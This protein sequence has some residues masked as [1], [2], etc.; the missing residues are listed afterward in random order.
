MTFKIFFELIE[1]KAKA[2]SVFPFI[3]GM[4]YSWFHFKQVNVGYMIIFFIAMFLFNMAVDI[5]DNYMDYHNATEDH[6]YKDKT[7]I[8]G[9]ENLSL[10]VIRLMIIG[11]IGIS[12][13]IGIWLAAQTSWVI[14]SLGIISYAI[15]ILYSA[16][17]I[18]L[19][20]LPV[21][22][23]A[24]GVAMGYL[25]PLICVYLNIY[26]VQEFNLNFMIKVLLMSIPAMFY[27]A[28]LMLANNTCDLEEDILNNR[29][30]LVYYLG[31]DKSLKLFS[32]LAYSPFMI[33]L[34][35]IMTEIAPITIIFTLAI[36]P[37]IVK[38]TSRFLMSQDKEKTF[39][40]AI[41]NLIIMMVVY[42][43]LFVIGSVL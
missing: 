27:I 11:L 33:I 10:P 24:S 6:D 3:L 19:S 17:P 35:L 15:G 37:F 30:T 1:L 36:L 39:P 29:Y 28:N 4:A 25:I 32:F 18:P 2:A 12:S 13:A 7:N 23:I 16:G 20:S 38:N 34:L 8:I 31:K 43:V 40:L 22:E 21:G 9:R 5:L 42:S 14:L 41:K 26:D